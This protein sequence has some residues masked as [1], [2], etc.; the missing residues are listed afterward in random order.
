MD[1]RPPTGR[2]AALSALTTLDDPARRAVYDL[3]CRRDEAVSREETAAALGVS[4]RSA[5]FHLDRLADQGLLAVEFRRLSGRSGPGAGRPSKLYRRAHDEVSVS[6][7]DRRYDLAG[8]VMAD[9]IERALDSGRPVQ[10]TLPAAA[11]E[12][13]RAIGARSPD[14]RAAL[15][16]HGFEPVDDGEGGLLLANCPFHRLATRHTDVVC[17]LNLHLVTGIA[18]ALGDTAHTCRLAPSPGHCCV[19]VDRRTA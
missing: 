17:G 1:A 2:T 14:L 4:R 7:P 6:V 12:A 5:A 3:V 19:R 8:D 11:A 15:T 18:Q 10:D 13:G 9:A 16:T